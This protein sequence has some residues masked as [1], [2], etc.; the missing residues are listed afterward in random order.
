MKIATIVLTIIAAGLIVFNVTKLNFNNLFQDESV[1]AMIT[2]TLS[3]CAIVLLQILRISKRIEK[4][5]KQ[6]RHV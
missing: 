4:L 5:S 1:V 6:K 3:L 2:I